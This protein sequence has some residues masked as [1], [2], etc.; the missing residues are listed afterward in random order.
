MVHVE[1][2][3]FATYKVGVVLVEWGVVNL[4]VMAADV[5]NLLDEVA[6]LSRSQQAKVAA[7]MGALVAD[8][9]GETNFC[10]VCG[11]TATRYCSSAAVLIFKAST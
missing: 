4:G 1:A 8:A 3:H 7:I 10:L 2:A 5:R 11:L 9:S 6:R